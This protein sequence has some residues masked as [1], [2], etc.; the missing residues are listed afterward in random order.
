MITS[1]DLTSARTAVAI[2]CIAIIAFFI[3][4]I[5]FGCDGIA[6]AACDGMT[7][8]TIG[9]TFVIEVDLAVRTSDT[10]GTV[11]FFAELD[12]AITAGSC[13]TGFTRDIASISLFAPAMRRTAII[14]NLVTVVAFFTASLDAIA[15]SLS[16]T[17]FTR[18]QAHI[19]RIDFAL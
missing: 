9:Q 17:V 11:A 10:T 14:G 4:S 7:C 12:D 2:L 18:R 19:T 3:R 13:H 8:T 15:A 1:F 5:S 6:I 16:D